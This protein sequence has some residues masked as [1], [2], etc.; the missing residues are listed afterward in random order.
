MP[1]LPDLQVFQRNLTKLL[2]GKKVNKVM[3]RNKKKLNVSTPALKKAIEGKTIKKVE[4]SGKELNILFNNNTVLGLHMM[5]HGELYWL[6]KNKPQKFSILE[7]YLNDD[8]KLVLADFQGQAV[9]TLN[10]E[11][12]EVPD[13]LSP[14]VNTNFLKKILQHKGTIKQV[15]MDQHLIRGIG[16]AYADEILWQA[17]ISPLSSAQ[18]IPAHTIKTL[19]AAI[20]KVLKH[21]EQQI[22]KEHP[23]IIGG[24]IRDFLVVHQPRKTH[25][26]DGARIKR[27]TVNSRKTYFTD[28]Q[29]LYK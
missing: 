14:S 8:N 18:K 27:T 25:T 3:V 26:P 24:E 15:L 4:R 2:R 9:P 6:E 10:P 16:N 20:K 23:D 1:E 7:L 29:E 13:A 28:E 17:G 11:L 22:L 5:L 12:S 19:A 21:A